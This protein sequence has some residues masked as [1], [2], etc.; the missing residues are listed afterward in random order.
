VIDVRDDGD[1]ADVVA[2]SGGGHGDGVSHIASE[3]PGRGAPRR[4]AC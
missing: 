2:S 3:R 1:V 4:P